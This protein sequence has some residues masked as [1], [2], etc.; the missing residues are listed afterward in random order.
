LGLGEMGGHLRNYIAM[1]SW[2]NTQNFIYREMATEKK[3]F[4]NEKKNNNKQ[5]SFAIGCWYFAM[6]FVSRKQTTLHRPTLLHDFA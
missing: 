6:H 3:I 5:H 4:A 2:C 1:S